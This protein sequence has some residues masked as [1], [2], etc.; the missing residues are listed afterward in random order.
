MPPSPPKDV[1][2]GE[3]EFLRANDLCDVRRYEDALA[4]YDRAVALGFQD[5]VVWNNRGVALDGLG[6]GEEAVASY[7]E[8]LSREA[9][10]EIGWYNLGNAR[11]HLGDYAGALAAY[12]RALALRQVLEQ[13]EPVAV[14]GRLA[15]TRDLAVQLL[16]QALS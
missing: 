1:T 15:D 4:A 16:F 11:A 7:E 9:D 3:A 14:T 12:D 13:L 6:R 8:C 5:H 2:R 10:Y